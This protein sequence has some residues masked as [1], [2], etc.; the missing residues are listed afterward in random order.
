MIDKAT[1]ASSRIIHACDIEHYESGDLC[2][3]QGVRIVGA[4][5][6]ALLIARKTVWLAESRAAQALFR[7]LDD[8][9]VGS[10]SPEVEL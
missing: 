3:Y 2:G 4:V 6:T 1:M 5:V 9:N 7:R 10:C 8:K